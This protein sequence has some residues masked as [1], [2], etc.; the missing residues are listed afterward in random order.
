M[1][2]DCR[3]SG[4]VDI[5]ISGAS[6]NL[7][8]LVTSTPDG[9]A[10]MT[11]E[12][13][14]LN[15]GDVH[16]SFH[17]SLWDW[18]INIFKGFIT[19]TVKSGVSSA[20]TSVLT[21]FI[22]TDLNKL[23]LNVPLTLPLHVS[24]PYNIAAIR[25]GLTQNPTFTAQYMGAALQGDI[26]PIANPVAP[27]LTPS[28]IPPFNAASGS[29]Y[30]QMH[31]SSYTALSAVYTYYHAGLM[32]RAVD[33]SSI[34]LGLNNTRGFAL[35]APGFASAYPNHAVSLNL[36][37]SS[38]P[39]IGISP[40]GVNITLPVNIEFIVEGANTVA[41]TL[42]AVTQLDAAVHVG[43]DSSGTLAISAV[44]QYLSSHI[45]VVSSNVGSVN[46]GLLQSYVPCH[47]AQL[48]VACARAHVSL[49][50]VHPSR[51]GWLTLCSRMWRC[52]RSTSSLQT[53]SHYPRLRGWASPTLPFSTTMAT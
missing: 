8:V 33:S 12:N 42:Q 25:F 32:H 4:H 20:F 16:L 14:N 30:L 52:P 38:M 39:A 15:L 47:P 40:S 23:L 49:S 29:R 18:L 48:H 2:D 19:R 35:I 9:H 50:R 26:V 22:R 17:G 31:M 27:P 1:G 24:A 53:V 7:G 37:A 3:G 10:Q 5:S 43:P 44:L 41:F 34:P 13:I 28:T 21:D 36:V 45:S 51:A 6:V 11:P 46:A